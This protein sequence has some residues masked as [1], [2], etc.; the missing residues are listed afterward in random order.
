MLY[1][2]PRAST[3]QGKHNEALQLHKRAFSIRRK[4]LGEN[5]HHTVDTQI[6]LE[7]VQKHIREQ[8]EAWYS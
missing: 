1:A 7:R 4:E 2:H 8:E 3:S 6:C 5:H